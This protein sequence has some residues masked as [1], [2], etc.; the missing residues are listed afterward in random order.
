MKLF[1]VIPWFHSSRLKLSNNMIPLRQVTEKKRYNR[2]FHSSTLQGRGG[3][4]G[5]GLTNFGYRWAAEGLIPCVANV[6]VRSMS[7][8]RGTRVKDRAKNGP[9]FHF[10]ALVSFLARSKPKI[11]LLGLLCSET[12]RKLLLR[13]LRVWNA[14]LV[15]DKKIVKYIPCFCFPTQMIF[16]YKFTL[17]SQF[18]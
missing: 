17:K 5:G 11:P 7:K 3:E 10:L 15:S 13:R 1:P 2:L 16:S 12:K 8:K 14:D 18:G 4:G 9:L 6:S